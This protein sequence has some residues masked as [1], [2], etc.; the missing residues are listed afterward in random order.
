MDFLHSFLKRREV[1][2][3]LYQAQHPP[4]AKRS[5]GIHIIPL[6]LKILL[7]IYDV[8]SF[9]LRLIQQVFQII[10]CRIDHRILFW[11]IPFE[12]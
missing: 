9:T 4:H 3:V 5:A 8:P 1:H 2:I 11:C 10:M 12:R 6:L 7:V